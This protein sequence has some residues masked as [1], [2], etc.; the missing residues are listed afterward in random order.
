M[1]TVTGGAAGLR[2]LG[3][4]LINWRIP[5]RWYLAGLTPVALYG[6][7]AVA[8]AR[9]NSLTANVDMTT[10]NT[11]LFSLSSGL[12]VSLFLRGAFGEELG[13]RGFALARLQPQT[14]SAKASLIIGLAWA[15]WHLPVLVARHPAVAA[16]LVAWIVGV[17]FTLPG[18]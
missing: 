4:R 8:T 6:A 7:A 5:T 16:L 1:I 14:G 3:A 2:R 18:L 13:L 10:V 9:P 17:S 12:F 15:L 11:I